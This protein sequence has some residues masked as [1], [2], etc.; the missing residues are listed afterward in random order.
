M[1][2]FRDLIAVRIAPGAFAPEHIDPR[3]LAVAQRHAWATK[4]RSASVLASKFIWLLS[5]DSVRRVLQN[6]VMAAGFNV[7][8]LL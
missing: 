6:V 1:S 2:R 3:K 8:A 7:A 5:K 4:T